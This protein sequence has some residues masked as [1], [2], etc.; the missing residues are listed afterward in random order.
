MI[1]LSLDVVGAC[2][3]RVP[4]GASDWHYLTQVM[5][6]E[7]GDRIEVLAEDGEVFEAVLVDGQHVEI[8]G[9]VANV[10]KPRRHIT[11]Y[12]ALL[13]GDHFSEVVERATEA[14]ISR[15]VPIVTE[16]SIVR[17]VSPN[18]AARWRAIAKEASEQCQR[19]DVPGI[20]EMKRVSD[21]R[22]AA[23]SDAFVLDPRANDARPWLVPAD[24]PLDIVIGPEGGFTPAELDLLSARGFLPLSL[25]E[26]V[27]RAEN[28]GAFAA[29]LFLQ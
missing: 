23:G 16:R 4:V 18:K 22:A 28:A 14:G 20:E 9:K 2:G 17:D 11:L 1:R 24:H 5:R 29:V 26:R 13:K 10:R 15:F 21:L 6:R 3:T 7:S 12:Q 27:Y 25:G 8:R 19:P